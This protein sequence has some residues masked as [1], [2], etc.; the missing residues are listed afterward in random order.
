MLGTFSFETYFKS[1]LCFTVWSLEIS[2]IANRSF[3]PPPAPFLCFSL[4]PPLCSVASAVE[5]PPGRVLLRAGA[6]ASPQ[7]FPTAL[8]FALCLPLPCHAPPPRPELPRGRHRDAAVERPLQSPPPT[9]SART[10]T[11]KAPETES[12]HSFALSSPPRSRT[13]PPPA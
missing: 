11:T 9:P 7:S 10:G 3:L 1:Y 5:S 8:G 12:P 6:H 4:P 2:E 13:A